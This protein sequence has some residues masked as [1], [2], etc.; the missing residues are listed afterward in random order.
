[1]NKAGKGP[2][3]VLFCLYKMEKLDMLNTEC[4]G[5]GEAY[6]NIK[7]F[8]YY[9]ARM[10]GPSSSHGW[11]CAA[12]ED[13]GPYRRAEVRSVVFT[14][15]GSAQTYKRHGTDKALVAGILGMEPDDERLPDSLPSPSS[16][17]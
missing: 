7:R 8:R 9:W 14:L 16:G 4:Q 2:D 1:M 17:D 11:G 15:Y 13:C 10:M 3:Q 5:E 6:E 12:G